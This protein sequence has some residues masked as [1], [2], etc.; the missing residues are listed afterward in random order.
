M[1]VAGNPGIEP[2]PS[3]REVPFSS[4]AC[5]MGLVEEAAAE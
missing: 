1:L 5:R 4:S 2:G 3:L